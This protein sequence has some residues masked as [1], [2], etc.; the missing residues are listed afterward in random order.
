MI[1]RSY[2][3]KGFDCAHCAAKSESHLN[4]HPNIEKA[5]IDFSMDRLDI[6]YRDKEMSIDDIKACI[7]EVESDPLTITDYG[8][9]VNKFRIFDKDFFILLGRI[10]YVILVVVL[11]FTAFHDD[12][13][14]WVNFG[15]YISAILVICYDIFFKVGLRIVHREN[16]IDEYLLIS[17]ATIGAFT[18][19]VIEKE[20]H[21]FMESVMVAT[22]FQIGRVVEGIA[23]NKS[24]EAV[25]EAVDLRVEYANKLVDGTVE[26]ISPEQLVVGDLVVA[27]AGEIIPIDGVVTDG[28]ALVDVS[29]L[30]GEFVPISASKDKHVFS[31]CLIKEGSVTIQATEEYSNSTVSRIMNLIT[32][33][34]KNKSKADKFVTKFAKWYTPTVFIISFLVGIIGSLVTSNWDEWMLLALKMLVVACPCAI[35]ISVPLAYFSGIGLAGKNGIVIKGSNYLD[36]LVQLDKV[37]TDKTGTLTKGDFKITK[38]ESYGISSDELLN[39]LFVVESYSNHPVGKAICLSIENHHEKIK[40]DNFVERAGYGVEC[41]YKGDHIIAG[42]KKLFAE[43]NIEVKDDVDDGVITYCAVNGKYVGYV[44]LS[45]EIKNDSYDMVN[46]LSK[47][48]IDVVLLTGDKRE[49]AEIFCKKLGISSYYAEL[50]P[51]EKVTYLNK[52]Q[53][54]GDTV[55]FIGDG[56]NDAPSIKGA[57]VGFAMG[58]IGSDTA[59]ENA[60]IVLMTD[61][62][63]KIYDA[64][65]IAK[66]TRNTAVFNIIFA[67]TVKIGIE[68]IAFVANLF[69][70]PEIIPMWA[71]VLADTGLTVLLVLN[72]LFLLYRKVK[73]S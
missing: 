67:L 45:D 64:F 13:F 61:N 7:K 11:S 25:M 36:E 2:T 38:S 4:K 65:K 6:V 73:K 46:L 26:R 10:I 39:Y 42:S 52:E 29:S 18:I 47:N 12:S 48:N 15:L 33:S 1:K 66:M 19:A 35:V 56:I 32:E 70:R 27:S 71:A 21:E 24:K 28:N 58:G 8:Q 72:S 62:P 59:V 37:V 3:I 16:P 31:G 55:A 68:I 9:K 14:F 22:L 41:D 49:N 63:R 30:T 5:A 53:S 51:D 60:D 44:V 50:L 54:S 69:G 57:D 40:V 34:R 43:H 23:T 17:I 20:A